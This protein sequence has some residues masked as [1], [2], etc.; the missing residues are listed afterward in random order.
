MDDR[1]LWLKTGDGKLSVFSGTPA[2]LWNSM[3]VSGHVPRWAKWFFGG[4]DLE[5]EALLRYT[6]SLSAALALLNCLPVFYLDGSN[7]LDN[8][9]LHF[10]GQLSDMVLE[11]VKMGT[12]FLVVANLLLS[13]KSLF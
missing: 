9:W 5:V 8:I 1:L 3:R 2:W 6:A 7:I 10:G 11:G 12:S 4:L 13:S